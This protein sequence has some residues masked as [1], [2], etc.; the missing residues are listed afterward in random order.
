MGR[1]S[2]FVARSAAAERGLLEDFPG[3]LQQL[4]QTAFRASPKLMQFF[5]DRD[6]NRRSGRGLR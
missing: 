3:T 1:Q 6:S 2:A 5:L 4:E